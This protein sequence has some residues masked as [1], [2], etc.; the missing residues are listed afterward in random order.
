MYVLHY[1]QQFCLIFH[2][3]HVSNTLEGEE[4]KKCHYHKL[5]LWSEDI[6]PFSSVGL[7]ELNTAARYKTVKVSSM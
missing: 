7:Q 5:P 1:K 6:F 4:K 3:V 2:R